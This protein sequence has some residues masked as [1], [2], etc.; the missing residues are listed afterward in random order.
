MQS[1]DVR[2]DNVSKF[3][4]ATKAVDGLN[5]EIA[6]GA[7]TTFL[8]PSGCGKTTT[9]RMIAGFFDPDIGDI[10]I[11]GQRQNGLPPFKRNVSIVFQEYALFPHMTVFEN[12]GYGLKVRKTP[13][14]EMKRKIEEVV[15][16][17]GLEG[18]ESRGTHQL[19]GGQQ[20]RVALARSLVLEPDVLLMDEPMSNLDAKLRVR[21]RAELRTL[22]QRLG[23]T[24]I[25]VT[26]DQEEALSLSDVVAVMDHGRL[27]QYSD[28]W[29]LYFRPQ[30]RFVADFV[31]LANFIPASVVGISSDTIQDDRKNG[32]GG[33]D[34]TQVRV[35]VAGH[36]GDV[37]TER[38][39]GSGDSA[40]ENNPSS[41]GVSNNLTVGN[42]VTL[43]VRPEWASLSPSNG[44]A[45][46]SP[47]DDELVLRGKVEAHSFLGTVIRYWVAVD[48]FDQ[49]FV[50]DKEARSPLDVLSGTVTLKVPWS[51]IHLVPSE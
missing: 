19:S 46:N 43:M 42:T 23:I 14:A 2:L 12:I 15:S 51:R 25:Y 24:T 13:K 27:Q 35:Q 3:F 18:L 21:L 1:T 11:K 49:L 36:E 48:Q 5:L 16:I 31:G 37:I 20:Q 4:G 28:P 8:G 30:N 45:D 50:V 10:Y 32:T 6:A 9:L 41:I 33:A 44:S 39:A 7:F 34:V 26:H 40:A 29:S 38:V 22:Q 47:S 17:L